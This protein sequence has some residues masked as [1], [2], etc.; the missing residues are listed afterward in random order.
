MGLGPYRPARDLERELD[1]GDLRMAI[2]AAKDLARHTGRP[3]PLALAVRLV[4]LAATQRAAVF[5]AFACRWLARWLQESEPLTI[6]RAAEVATALAELPAVPS[7]LEVITQDA[8]S[9]K[10]TPSDR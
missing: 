4:A 9:P 2:A 6:D 5:D 1:R 3:I 7:A 10:Q 8:S